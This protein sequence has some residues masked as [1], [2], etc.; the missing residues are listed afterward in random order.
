M[1]SRSKTPA[2]IQKQLAGNKSLLNFFSKEKSNESSVSA[3]GKL[4]IVSD[5]DY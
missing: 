4:S 3:T 2:K 5:N 1:L